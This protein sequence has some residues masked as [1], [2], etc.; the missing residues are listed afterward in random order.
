MNTHMIP[1]SFGSSTIRVT[2]DDRGEPWFVASDIAKEL[3]YRDAHNLARILDEE[4]KGTR[5][6]STPSGSQEMTVINE[7]GLYSAIV[8][9]RKPEAKQFKR[10]VTGEVLPS[11]R[12]N[13]GY[14]AG[15]E[16]DDPELIMAKALQ[17]A[18]SVIARKS[19]E[20]ERAKQTIAIQAPAVE[21]ATRVAGVEKGVV[22]GNFARTI[23]IGQNTLFKH[24]RNMRVLMEGGNRHNLPLQEY[25]DRGYFTVRESTYETN[26]ETRLSFTPLITGKGQQWL[27]GKLLS[28]GVLRAV[29]AEGGAH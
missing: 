19:A 2:T 22:L 3:G 28:A 13:G 1:F 20:L 24:L 15:Q 23:G 17:V 29:A 21:F 7:S 25:I 6:V 12:K 11:I 16:Q 26:G 4:E 8:S 18:Q 5:V 27:S 9:S 14:I 10:W